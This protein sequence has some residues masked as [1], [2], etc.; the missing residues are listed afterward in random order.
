MNST[1]YLTTML[2][3]LI[4]APPEQ[5][6]M[7]LEPLKFLEDKMPNSVIENMTL[8]GF[9]KWLGCSI[10]SNPSKMPNDAFNI[11]VS[12]CKSAKHMHKLKGAICAKCYCKGRHYAYGV[13]KKA[14]EKRY[15]FAISR[16]FVPVMSS[17]L[18]KR[19]KSLMNYYGKNFKKKFGHDKYRFR[20]FDSGDLQS[21]KMLDDIC[22]I[23]R[24][25]PEIIHWLPTREWKTVRLYLELGFWSTDD[26]GNFT[27]K[28]HRELPK[29]L[30]VRLSALMEGGKP[31]T[32][33]ARRLG[34]Q[35]STALPPERL[36]KSKKEKKSW[37]KKLKRMK[38]L[39]RASEDNPS[40]PKGE[41]GSCTACWVKGV[42]NV[43]YPMH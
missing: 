2:G 30:T 38:I 31:P 32:K 34:L 24:N 19:R 9:N 36:M 41:C 6:L 21:P 20:W 39:C 3:A 1:Q 8:G 29:N 7:Y 23:C 10:L 40:S 18:T 4:R 25:T 42:I 28:K 16:D 43:A 15:H 13:V 37:R 17:Y 22:K 27:Y 12:R 26:D 35:T 11:P 5:A 33:L 14:L